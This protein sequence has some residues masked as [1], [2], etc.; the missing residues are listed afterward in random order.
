MAHPWI[1]T[2]AG[3][4]SA[5]LPIPGLD[6][7]PPKARRRF[8]RHRCLQLRVA[9]REHRSNRSTSSMSTQLFLVRPSMPEAGQVELQRTG[10]YG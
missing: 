5:G 10:A 8:I 4:L 3:H 2:L 1:A 9:V 7:S 6:R